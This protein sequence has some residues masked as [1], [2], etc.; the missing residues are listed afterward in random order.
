MRTY[1]AIV[2]AGLVLGIA[3]IA[4][5][6]ERPAVKPEDRAAVVKGANDFALELYAQ[7]RG[8][9][10]NLFFSPYSISTA[11]AMTYAGARGQT[12]DE[13]AKTLH[14]P[15]DPERLHPTLAVL[16]REMNDPGKPR[17]YRLSVANALWGQ[18]GYA[19]R[20]DFLKL[21]RDNYDAGLNELDFH[22]ATEAARQTINAWVEKQTQDK[23]KEL[24]QPGILDAD[25]RLVLT[26]AI[27]FKGDWVYQFEQKLTQE[28]DF[29][30]SGRQSVRAPL[31]NMVNEKGTF[32]YLK[33]DGFRALELPYSGKHLSM[34]LFLPEK[35]DGLTE[36]EKGL[37]AAKV[38]ASIAKLQPTYEVRVTLPKFKMTREFKLKDVLMKMG[39]RRAFEPGEADF[40]GM[41]GSRDLFLSAVVHKA[42]V[43]VN[44][45]GT[46]AAAA[47]AVV[48]KPTAV[49]RDPPIFRA[50]HPFLF[51]IRDNR[52][53]SILFLGR[54][55]NP[56]K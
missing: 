39:M 25:T 11:L 40:S 15:T 24:L 2:L 32:K 8:E 49:L 38:N 43:H 36:F 4:Q 42:F 1:P 44:E 20:N 51:L 19:F 10:G 18:K 55:A 33:G 5:A 46:E 35:V 37:T 47:T 17:G 52:S 26:N 23:I 16:I 21:V 56:V 9:D 48:T 53:G 30:V 31:M 14:F 29:H 22:T 34:V 50:D 45:E 28:G 12:A 54:V 13:M 41:T 3:P 27:Y 7:L 6:A